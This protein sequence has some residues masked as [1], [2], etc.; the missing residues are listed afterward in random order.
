MR[1]DLIFITAALLCLLFGEG[2]GLYMGTNENF[3]LAP[4][5]AHL[6]LLGWVTLAAYG[7]LHRAYPALATSRLAAFQC[8][9]AVLSNVAMPVGLAMVLLGGDATLVKV[10]S[11]TVLLA[12]LIFVIMF[13][14]KVALAK[15]A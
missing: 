15:A 14:R 8:W 4:A 12:T 10:A 9:F 6:N 7:L 2:L 5:H 1:Y 13:V 3:L 11:S